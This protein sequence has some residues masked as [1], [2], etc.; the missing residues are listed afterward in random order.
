MQ[1][2]ITWLSGKRNY[3]VGAIIYNVYGKDDALKTLLAK[4]YSQHSYDKLVAALTTIT[5][6]QERLPLYTPPADEQSE[7]PESNDDV[8]QALRDEWLPLYK[9]M[10]Y[11]IGQLDKYGDDNSPEA[12][13]YR[14]PIAAEVLGLE[15]RIIKIWQKRDHYAKTGQ[16]P[17]AKI[18]NSKFQIPTDPVELGKTIE[19]HKKSIRRYKQWIREKVNDPNRPKWVVKL[20]KFEEELKMMTNG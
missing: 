12:Q 6:T 13:N 7:M 20:G 9:Q 3:T 10:N 15:Q 8:L 19:S 17:E 1:P 14:K 16:L 11:Q 2:V 18:S 5:Q 4:G